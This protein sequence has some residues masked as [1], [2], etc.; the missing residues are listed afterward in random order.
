MKKKVTCNLTEQSP[1]IFLN[2]PHSKLIFNYAK[3]TIVLPKLFRQSMG[4]V[5]YVIQ[6][7]NCYGAILIKSAK[8]ISLEEFTK[9][10]VEHRITEKER[11]LWWKEKKVLFTYF[12]DIV[13]NFD[14]PKTI[15]ELKNRTFGGNVEFLSEEKPI[16]KKLSEDIE[17][18]SKIIKS[19]LSK[20]EAI[21]YV[22]EGKFAVEKMFGGSRILIYKNSDEI[23]FYSFEEKKWVNLD[24]FKEEADKLSDKNF[25]V[26]GEF[27]AQG[28]QKIYLF[29]VLR[30]DDDIRNLSWSDRK[31]RLHSLK[32]TDKIIETP[33]I[34]INSQS[35]GEEAIKFLGE[36]P[37][38][39]GVMIKS[40]ESKYL[41]DWCKLEN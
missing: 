30:L 24:S 12:F 13:Q 40:Y 26:D 4:K 3:R 27:V 22:N 19:F 29:D 35:E 18:N 34:I 20:E 17:P 7:N 33:S 28:K 10:R 37:G 39:I 25:V 2:A 8:P 21:G 11:E 41:Q 23:K 1:S 9:T 32:F 6:E 5:Y 15:K 31:S 16:I 38:S 36:L 14:K